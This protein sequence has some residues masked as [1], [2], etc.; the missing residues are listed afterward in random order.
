MSRSPIGF[1]AHVLAVQGPGS[2]I[3][4]YILL[5]GKNELQERPPFCSMLT[6]SP[7]RSFMIRD[8]RPSGV[9][10]SAGARPR[11][12]GHRCGENDRSTIL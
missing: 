5:P 7:T 6:S 3:E 9:S 10:L 4:S 1:S 2:D 11:C 8:K 12:N